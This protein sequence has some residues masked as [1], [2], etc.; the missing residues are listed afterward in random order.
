MQ[1]KE[2]NTKSEQA[3]PSLLDELEIS[4]IGE[5][6][7]SVSEC[8]N[9]RVITKAEIR[10]IQRAQKKQSSN[11]MCFLFHSRVSSI[12]ISERTEE[13]AQPKRKF[14]DKISAVGDSIRHSLVNFIAG[15]QR[16]Q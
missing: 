4:S 10:E 14:S 8:D 1:D 15:R 5:I 7:D 2:D 3:I 11:L 9:E 6:S 13:R 12:S 16:E